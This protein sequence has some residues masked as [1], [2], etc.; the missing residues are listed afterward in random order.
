MLRTLTRGLSVL[1]ALNGNKGGN[2]ELIARETHVSRGAVHRILETLTY[3]GYVRHV[4]GRYAPEPRLRILAAGLEDARWLEHAQQ[5]LDE[6]CHDL[7][8]PVSVWRP[9]GLAMET[10]AGTDSPFRHRIVGLGV[11]LPMACTAAGRA[12]MAFLAENMRA[13]LIEVLGRMAE[14]PEDQEMCRN[15]RQVMEMLTT[16]AHKGLAT[17]AVGRTTVIAIPIVRP[18]G[19]VLGALTLRHFTASVP[20]AEVLRLHLSQIQTTARRIAAGP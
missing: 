5:T 1:K 6:L 8:W 15:P 20:T 18:N 7:R 10:C 13:Q 19:D 17:A 16:I 4:K 14:F 11:R 2:I 3:E 12:Y 9:N